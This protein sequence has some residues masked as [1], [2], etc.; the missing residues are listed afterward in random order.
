[1]RGGG[2]GGAGIAVAPGE[3]GHGGALVATRVKHRGLVRDVDLDQL[4]GVLAGVR[5]VADHDSER[6]T[7]VADGV[8]G[9]H[10]LQEAAQVSPGDGEPDRDD[11][12]PREVFRRDNGGDPRGLPRL[13][14]VELAEEAMS[15]RGPYDPDPKLSR[16]AHV[17]TEAA[18]PAQQARVF[19]TRQPGPDGGHRPAGFCRA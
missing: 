16:N 19:V 10:R 9:Q 8:R 15:S 14:D 6:L 17:V 12:V 18:A 1:M 4:G 3:F 13:G 7:H 2:E 11:Q 5:V